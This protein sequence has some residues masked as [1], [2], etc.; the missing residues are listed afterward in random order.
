MDYHR[1]H[2]VDPWDIKVSP[3]RSLGFRQASSVAGSVLALGFFCSICRWGFHVFS[4]LAHWHGSG[5]EAQAE[6]GTRL[7]VN[8]FVYPSAAAL[9]IFLGILALGFVRRLLL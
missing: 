8:A 6:E 7:L 4:S 5:A 9:L 1:A 2:E 3:P